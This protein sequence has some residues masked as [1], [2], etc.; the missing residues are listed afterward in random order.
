MAK[1]DTNPRADAKSYSPEDVRKARAEQAQ[2]NEVPGGQRRVKAFPGQLTARLV[3]RG[4]KQFYHL[5]GFATVFERGYEMWDMFGE[6]KEIMDY[7]SLSKSLAGNP[8]VAFLVNHSGVTMA[9]TTSSTLELATRTNEEGYTGLHVDAY[10][11]P[12]RQDV[13][14]FVSAVVDKNVDEMSFAFMLIEGEW[15]DD[16]SVFRILEADIN[17][18]DVSGVNYGANPFT[19][20]Q[21]RSA[22]W[23]ADI[24]RVPAP[25][26]REAF[27][28]IRARLEGL[29]DIDLSDIA[30]WEIVDETGDDDE[31]ETE[32]TKERSAPIP[33]MTG[34]SAKLWKMRLENLDK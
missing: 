32:T 26:A 13:R 7:N 34:K 3:E 14:D 12:D 4:G 2:R 24:S 25:V 29:G 20:I 17:R 9:R 15:N 31:A 28:Q 5:E 23:L 8:D 27:A 16:F 10:L 33:E 1:T 19:S 11:N 22:D 18:G 21:A 6:Y 30:D